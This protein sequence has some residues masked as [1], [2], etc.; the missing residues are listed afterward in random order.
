MLI[1]LPYLDPKRA[2]YLRFT[3]T[4]QHIKLLLVLFFTGL[5]LTVLA[6]GL[7][8]QN[9]PSLFI[10]IAMPLLFIF[11]G[12]VMGQ[13]RHNYFVGIRTPWTIAARRYG[14]RPIG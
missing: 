8:Y 11:F 14:A 12:N 6:A 3:S 10:R 2:N 7:G 13:I 5:H 4:Y 1:L 9:V